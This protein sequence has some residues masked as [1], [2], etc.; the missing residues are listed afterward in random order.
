M[1]PSSAVDDVDGCSGDDTVAERV[2]FDDT[3]AEHVPFSVAGIDAAEGEDCDSEA[4]TADREALV[5]AM[6]LQRGTRNNKQTEEIC[7]L[8]TLR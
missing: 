8:L 2:P 1:V 6:A 7:P 5:S 3:V 4:E